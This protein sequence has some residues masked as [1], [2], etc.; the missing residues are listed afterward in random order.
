MPSDV[1]RAV[2]TGSAGNAAPDDRVSPRRAGIVAGVIAAAVAF[3][4][5]NVHAVPRQAVAAVGG[6]G[7]GV[8]R[9]GG[10]VAMW[11]PPS[12]FDLDQLQARFDRRDMHALLAREGDAVRVELPGIRERDA[13]DAIAL[14]SAGGVGF[15]P[16]IE[17]DAAAR[18]ADTM[19]LRGDAGAEPMLEIDRWRP[20]DRDEI[21]TDHY[22]YA[23]DRATLERTFAAAIAQGWSPPRDSEIVYERVE[24]RGEA[25][26]PRVTW[27]SYF[28]TR[29]VPIDGGSIADATGSYDPN[30]NRPIVLVDFD[31]AGGL[32]F[33]ELTAK[34]AGQKLAIIVGGIVKSAPVINSPIRGGRA[35]IT[36]G[37]GDPAQ[38]EHDRDVL[39]DVLRAGSLPIG[40]TIMDAHWAAP[41]EH[42]RVIAARVLLALLAG[43]LGFA[44]AFVTIRAT[45]P[46]R[47]TIAPIP[48]GTGTRVWRRLAWTIGAVL[49][50]LAG[51]MFTA[52]GI[53]GVELDHIV[54]RGSASGFD[55]LID[56]ANPFVL[57]VT[58]LFT[59]FVAIEL[60]ASIVRRWR[61]LRDTVLGR[62]KLGLAVAIAACAM[63]I[64]QA[65]FVATYMAGFP[66]MSV[67]PPG[68]FWLAVASIAAGPMVL[69]VL[70]SLIST[71]GLGNGYG[72]LI[73]VGW[74]WKPIWRIVVDAPASELALAAVAIAATAI[75]ALAMVSWRVRSPGRVAIPLPLAGKLPLYAG[76]GA[77]VAIAALSAIHLEL[78]PAFELEL[79]DLAS[80]RFAG[81]IVLV[82][83]TIAWGW[84]FARPGRRRTELAPALEPADRDG[85]LRAV[86]IT[87]VALAALYVLTLIA[88]MHELAEPALV[89]VAVLAIADAIAD[90]RAHS[91]ADLVA[92]WPLHDPLLVDAAR[93]RLDAACIPY[94][95]QSTRLRLLL[96]IAGSY[97]PMMVLVPT[98]RAEAAHVLMRDWLSS[99]SGNG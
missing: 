69:A 4:Y 94:H 62:R 97:V 59:A 65:Y 96:W 50:Y 46:E 43:V 87:V 32:T 73:A 64:V 91:R 34:I 18:L 7:V 26:D 23:H 61:P 75:I 57:G 1:P 40:G 95:I 77:I 22:L 5:W 33:G 88:P 24:P 93:D 35:S 58:P 74:L 98:D 44:L 53:N 54:V 80:A 10:V 81:A 55:S 36:M 15:R 42:G 60:V 31:R 39:V 47:R 30:T 92:V 27:R 86:G 83:A 13:A 41:S 90:W 38:M 2:A 21:H 66:A 79:R 9:F 25:K 71:R 85:W 6:S 51:T 70:A 12:G 16:V 76:G 48:D 20:D 14:I 37:T 49:V 63:A 3:A 89:S 67:I 11:M 78:P 29:D 82:V 99:P 52:P 56:Y 84:V 19:M 17:S 28:V 8:A 72:I 68:M 45:R